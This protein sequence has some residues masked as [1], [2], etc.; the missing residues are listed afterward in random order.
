MNSTVNNYLAALQ[1]KMAVLNYISESFEATRSF[2][3]FESTYDEMLETHFIYEEDEEVHSFRVNDNAVSNVNIEE[4]GI[5][6]EFDDSSVVEI[7][8]TV[9]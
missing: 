5:I 8:S 9:E 6:I 3:S 2:V 1:G 4:E 7:W